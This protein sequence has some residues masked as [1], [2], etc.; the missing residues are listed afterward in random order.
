MLL[1]IGLLVLQF[2]L[3]VFGTRQ[4][5]DHPKI[6][7]PKRADT[8]HEGCFGQLHFHLQSVKVALQG[9]PYVK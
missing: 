5:K 2:V 8:T 7:F 6:H 9:H 4:D 3:I 1:R